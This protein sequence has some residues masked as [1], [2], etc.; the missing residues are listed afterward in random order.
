MM[1]TPKELPPHIKMRNEKAKALAVAMPVKRA[2]A[3]SET[4]SPIRDRFMLF[5]RLIDVEQR[6]LTDSEL[7]VLLT[8]F[9]DSKNGIAETA[10]SDLGLRTGKRRETTCR[11]IKSL[12][13]KG[14]VEV[15]RQGGLI[16]SEGRRETSRYIGSLRI[17]PQN[18]SPK[19]D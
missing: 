2:E 12:V 14:L 17:E 5:N 11:A 9:R 15:V 6:H 19:S 13:E 10:Q 4:S 1:T 3:K 18:G 7:R 16:G 8:L